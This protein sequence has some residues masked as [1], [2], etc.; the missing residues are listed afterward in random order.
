MVARENLLRAERVRIGQRRE[1]ALRTGERLVPALVAQIE[2]KR[3]RLDTL[4]QLFGSLNYKAVLARGYALVWDADGQAVR[5]PEDV[6]DGQPLTVEFADGRA[7]VTGGRA[8]RV[9]TVRPKAPA[10]EQGALF[11]LTPTP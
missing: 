4:A 11:D 1:L 3:T 6:L 7:D 9:K 10:D 8:M 2:R 5:S